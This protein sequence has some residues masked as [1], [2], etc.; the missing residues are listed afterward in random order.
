VSEKLIGTVVHYYP[1]V[2]VAGV[3][4][5]GRLKVGDTIHVKGHTTDF[6]G[7]VESMQIDHV[8]VKKAKKG[9]DIGIRVPD[10]AREHDEV[11]RVR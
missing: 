3:V 4:L 11:Y 10:R 6:T 7:T 9:D 1:Q 5:S 2:G 8:E